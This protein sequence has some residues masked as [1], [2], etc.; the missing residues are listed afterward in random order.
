MSQSNPIAVAFGEAVV[1]GDVNGFV[2]QH[3][4]RVLIHVGRHQVNDPVAV[5]EARRAGPGRVGFVED[6]LARFLQP[7]DQIG[8]DR[9]FQ[10]GTGLVDGGG[11]DGFGRGGGSANGGFH[12]VDDGLGREKTI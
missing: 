7:V 9:T 3:A 6:Q 11:L 1:A 8:A 5:H 4:R 10:I 12:H 2:R